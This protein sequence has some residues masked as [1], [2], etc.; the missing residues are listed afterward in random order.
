MAK[1][2]TSHTNNKEMEGKET[3]EVFKDLDRGALDTERFVEKHAKTL[4]TIFGAM[5]LAVLVARYSKNCFVLGPNNVKICLAYT[6]QCWVVGPKV[7]TFGK[8][9][10]W[11]ISYSCGFLVKNGD[12]SYW[13]V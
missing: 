13:H 10:S 5:V 1:Q 11:I 8:A 12:C 2:H 7:W 4:M 6:N 3:V 9:C